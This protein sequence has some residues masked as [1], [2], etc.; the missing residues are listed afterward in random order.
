MFFSVQFSSVQF[1][2]S[3]QAVTC[4]KIRGQLETWM[5]C[6][7]KCC[8]I[9]PQRIEVVEFGP[10]GLMELRNTEARTAA[11][12]QCENPVQLLQ[13]EYWFMT[14]KLEHV[15]RGRRVDGVEGRLARR[16][17][18]SNRSFDLF[19]RS[20]AAAM[21]AG[22]YVPREYFNSQAVCQ[23]STHEILREKTD[24]G[25]VRRSVTATKLNSKLL[26]LIIMFFSVTR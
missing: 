12:A 23:L 14:G 25:S 16:L 18:K 6:C 19:V 17:P 2:D 9:S 13:H 22:D 5:N 4:D 20:L 7:A 24:H 10:S 21:C 26:S 15:R 3:V 1:I 8:T 11:L